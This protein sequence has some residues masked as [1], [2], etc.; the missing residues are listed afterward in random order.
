MSLFASR[1]A[2]SGLAAVALFCLY[3]STLAQEYT[4]VPDVVVSATRSEQNTVTIP[5]SISA[6]LP[7]SRLSK[8]VPG[9]S[10]MCCV[11]RAGFRSLIRLVTAAA[12]RS[13]CGAL[14]RLPTPTP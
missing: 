12:P 3:S 4:S 10:P 14:A 9:I 11:V 6:S 13:V 2:R 1:K 8:A 7:A 5:A